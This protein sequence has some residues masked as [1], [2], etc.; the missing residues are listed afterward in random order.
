MDKRNQD[1]N[2]NGSLRELNVVLLMKG[3]R[4]QVY[5]IDEDIY[6]ISGDSDWKFWTISKFRYPYSY[7]KIMKSNPEFNGK[8]WKNFEN[9]NPPKT[10]E[11]REVRK[12]IAPLLKLGDLCR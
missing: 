6:G 4:F 5:A 11:D 9:W 2:G 1:A 7:V 10:E 8:V 12:I 3:E